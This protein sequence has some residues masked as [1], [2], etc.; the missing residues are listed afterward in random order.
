MPQWL[1][2]GSNHTLHSKENLVRGIVAGML[3]GGGVVLVAA[4]QR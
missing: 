3:E 4:D 1:I 2:V